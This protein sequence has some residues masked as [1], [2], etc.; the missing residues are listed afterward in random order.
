MVNLAICAVAL[1]MLLFIAHKAF[2]FTVYIKHMTGVISCNL[3]ETI[4]PNTDSD[5]GGIQP[6]FRLYPDG[7]MALDCIEDFRN[8]APRGENTMVISMYEG[9]LRRLPSPEELIQAVD[10]MRLAQCKHAAAVKDEGYKLALRLEALPEHR[11]LRMGNQDFVKALYWAFFRR[12]PDA[13]GLAYWTNYL[14]TNIRHNLIGMFA[15]SGEFVNHCE[16][17]MTF[18]CLE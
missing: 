11:N 8:V 5:N 9:F 6:G 17:V 14:N 10:V 12:E 1:L 2:G 3:K 18:A 13:G 16:Y 15:G 4:R 7:R